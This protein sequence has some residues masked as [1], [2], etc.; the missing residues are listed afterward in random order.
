MPT[1][2]LAAVRLLWLALIV[3]ALLA[4][5]DSAGEPQAG[6]VVLAASS[7]QEAL[8][9]AGRAW[10]AEGHA[11]PV[12]SF[13]ASSA[14]ARQIEQGAPA[15]LFVSADEEWMDAL[16]RR[17]ALRT[18]SRADLLT[19]RLVLVGR[20]GGT[21]RGLADL[22]DG[23]LALA[24]PAA[25]PAGKY[26]KA[27]LES[28]GQWRAVEAQVVPAENV[29]AAL[30]LVERGEAALGIVYA[31]DAIASNAVEVLETFPAS[32]HP[33][34]RYPAAELAASRHGDAA[35]LLAFLR[36]ARA[37]RIFVSHGFGI[38]R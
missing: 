26:A 23:K 6:P 16:A 22:A 9:E 12:L 20:N 33:P 18:G 8:E 4:C 28:A 14:L 29:R 27:A 5:G 32:S 37:R 31:T 15:D 1:R 7:L 11:A 35:G 21:V 2:L 36:S 10:A 34:I 25:V 38:A 30:A 19:N 3:P 17:G 13:A 24:D